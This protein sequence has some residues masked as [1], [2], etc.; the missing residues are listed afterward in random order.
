HARFGLDD[1]AQARTNQRLVVGDQH[2]D[3]HGASCPGRGIAA[4]T[5][6]P[7]P[8]RAPVRRVPPYAATRS[9]IP[10]IPCAVLKAGPL[11]PTPSS[12]TDTRT[13]PRLPTMV[14][15]AFAPSPACLRTLVSDSC[16]IR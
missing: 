12:C 2:R 3:G 16:T 15:P 14:T 11:G 9:R 6:N 1:R 7:P 5:S 13:V 8:A 10:T 4:S